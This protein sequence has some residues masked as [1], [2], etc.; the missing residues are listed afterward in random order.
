MEKRLIVLSDLWG[1]GKSEWLVNYTKI[2]CHNFK[3]VYYD[4]CELGELNISNYRDENLHHQFLN[5][6]I[7]KAVEK[8]I[9]LEK[10][11]VNILA[12]SVG[13]TIAWK[14]GLKSERL[15][16]LICVSST[17]LRY[18]VDKPEADI[19]LFFGSEDLNKP[20]KEW[21]DKMLI[22][23]IIVS[24]TNHECYRDAR[25]AKK[26]CDLILATQSL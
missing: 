9:E 26:I 13:G 23:P 25:L 4:C 14:F 19:A 10:E 24:D 21:F 22:D 8:L 20:K 2:L 7:E 3:I 17:R 12:F 1:K 5:G 15:N 16:S 6:G 18:E 11:A